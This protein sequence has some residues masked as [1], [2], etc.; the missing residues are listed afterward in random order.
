M[1][2]L[3]LRAWVV[4][5]I[6]LAAAAAGLAA[7]SAGSPVT[8]LARMAL[9]AGVLA[10]YAAVVGIV[11]TR[12]SSRSRRRCLIWGS[13]VPTAV[14]LINGA[15]VTAA[16][17][18]ELGLLSALP[19]LAGAVLVSALGPLLPELRLP[20]WMRRRRLPARP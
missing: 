14:G 2:T 18:I 11:V 9:A 8:S 13:T 17:G 4:S 15:L 10:A 12:R 3:T 20:A 7:L 16:A 19:W 1:I 6:A 5:A